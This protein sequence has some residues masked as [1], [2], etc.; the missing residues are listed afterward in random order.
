MR[1]QILLVMLSA[2]VSALTYALLQR[3]P[4]KSRSLQE[5]APTWHADYL[6]MKP[7]LDH[8]QPA[9]TKTLREQYELTTS[10]IREAL[11]T[12]LTEKE[13][14]ELEALLQAELMQ[15]AEAGGILD[16]NIPTSFETLER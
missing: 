5:L 14:S 9:P 1:K 12:D 3:T 4:R 8:N 10:I 2:F 6:K 7:A 16:L 13:A 11:R 15:L